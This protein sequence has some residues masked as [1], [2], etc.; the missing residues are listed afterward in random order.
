MVDL[1]LGFVGG[2]EADRERLERDEAWVGILTL[3]GLL[4][5][6]RVEILGGARKWVGRIVDRASE[7]EAMGN[8]S[9]CCCSS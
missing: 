4:E 3:L 7:I 9:G 8:V 6:K 1:K 2:I 5:L